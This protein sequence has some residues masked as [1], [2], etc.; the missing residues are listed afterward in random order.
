MVNY[1]DD[2]PIFSP[3]ALDASTEA[4]L[5]VGWLGFDYSWDKVPPFSPTCP[6]LGVEVD[7]SGL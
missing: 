6:A 3:A 1:F 4:T 7:C 5:L 2:Y